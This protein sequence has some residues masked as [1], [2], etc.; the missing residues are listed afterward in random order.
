MSRKSTFSLFNFWNLK[1]EKQLTTS[2]CIWIL[3]CRFMQTEQKFN[4]RQRVHNNLL[5]LFIHFVCIIYEMQ[6]KNILVLR[7]SFCLW[8][9]ILLA[10]L[11]VCNLS[12]T[13]ST[14]YLSRWSKHMTMIIDL[15]FLKIFQICYW[16][17]PFGVPK[18]Q[19]N[20][21]I[22]L[23]SM[24]LR[25]APNWNGI[26]N[27]IMRLFNRNFWGQEDFCSLFSQ[28]PSTLYFFSVC[29]DDAPLNLQTN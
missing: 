11:F 15:I 14:L 1:H 24:V 8:Q 23:Y 27:K 7:P 4:S 13:F 25:H 5:Y 16:K 2:F 3:F 12:V 26:V 6:K 10:P 17:Y 28:Q 18:W 20:Q 22:V 9:F 29:L 19:F 21:N